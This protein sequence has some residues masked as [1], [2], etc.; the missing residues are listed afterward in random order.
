M[1]TE[2]AFSLASAGGAGSEAHSG[3]ACPAPG[4][5]ARNFSPAAVSTCTSMPLNGILSPGFT[6]ICF[7]RRDFLVCHI[8]RRAFACIFRIRAMIHESPDLHPARELGHSAGVVGMVVRDD[9][10][11]RCGDSRSF[12]RGHDAI[13]VPVL[14]KSSHPVSISRDSPCGSTISVDCPPSTSMK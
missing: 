1:P 14:L 5:G 3:F 9:P 8:I 6:T 7:L 12:R 13:R 2:C 10:G 4:S 11:N